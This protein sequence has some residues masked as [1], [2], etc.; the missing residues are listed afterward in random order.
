MTR[1]ACRRCDWH[2]AGDAQ[3]AQ[4]AD[5]AD[6][7]GHPLCQVCQLSLD[8]TERQVCLLCVGQVR[9][10]LHRI[11]DLYATLP[12]ELGHPKGPQIDPSGGGRHDDEQPIPGGPILPLLAGGSRGLTQITGAPTTAGGRDFSHDND[13]HTSDPQSVAF[14]LSRHEDLWRLQRGEPA[15]ETAPTVTGCS[16]YLFRHLTWAA[17]N[18]E[19]FLDLSDAL[20]TILYRLEAVTSTSDRPQVGV[21]CF[22]DGCGADLIRKYGEDHYTCPRCRRQYDDAAYWLAVR[23]ALEKETA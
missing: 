16:G 10:N 11:G 8:R 18:L 15:A 23:A 20:A 9:R 2:P 14:E 7:A 4:L 13:E 1:Y 19:D 17:D 22:E 3:R 12:D 21:P 6:E 5:H